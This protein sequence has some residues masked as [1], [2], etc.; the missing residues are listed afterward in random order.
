MAGKQ[1]KMKKTISNI[2]KAVAYIA[3]ANTIREGLGVQSRSIYVD[4][5]KDVLAI[6]KVTV[7]TGRGKNKV[8]KSVKVTLTDRPAVKAALIKL[9]A[10]SSLPEEASKKVNTLATGVMRTAGMYRSRNAT[11]GK[12]EDV[13]DANKLK[14]QKAKDKGFDMALFK[15]ALGTFKF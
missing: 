6:G 14:E 4:L 7:A 1:D 15:A 12:M 3:V 9:L 13:K 11:T 2:E 8:E 10:D 5:S